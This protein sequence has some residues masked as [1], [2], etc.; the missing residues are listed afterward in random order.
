VFIRGEIFF[1]GKAGRRWLKE[2]WIGG[3]S[4]PQGR[5]LFRGLVHSKN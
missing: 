4:L 2:C 1:L 3:K 5:K